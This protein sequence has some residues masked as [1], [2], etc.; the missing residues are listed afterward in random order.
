MA[1]A[2]GLDLMKEDL[3]LEEFAIF[4]WICFHHPDWVRADFL[5]SLE[6]KHSTKGI[7]EIRTV[8]KPD[9]LKVFDMAFQSRRQDGKF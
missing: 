6:D 4:Y 8:K 1:A 5:K 9:F 3:G 2:S 7:A